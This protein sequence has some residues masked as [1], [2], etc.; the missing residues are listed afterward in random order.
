[1]LV[2]RGYDSGGRESFHQLGTIKHDFSQMVLKYE[3]TT[4]APYVA[5]GSL[6]NAVKSGRLCIKQH[7]PTGVA[8]LPPVHG[9]GTGAAHR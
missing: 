8:F 5:A 9:P 4:A 7:R 2:T 6:D 3:K 1:M